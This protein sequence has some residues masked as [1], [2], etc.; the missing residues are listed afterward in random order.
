MTMTP[1]EIV[2]RLHLLGFYGHPGPYTGVSGEVE[3]ALHEFAH[4]TL[5]GDVP[6]RE[7]ASIIDFKLSALERDWNE[8]K[9]LAVS[10][11]VA[12][13]LGLKL[14]LKKLSDFAAQNMCTMHFKQ[15]PNVR[16]AVRRILGACTTQDLAD[17]M[18]DKIA[19]VQ[20]FLR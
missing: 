2:D 19:N 5:L 20:L 18:V 3:S 12:E 11:V 6:E 17:R 4:S 1:R 7:I 9:T 16:R 8:V 14:S 13:R 10:L 15:R